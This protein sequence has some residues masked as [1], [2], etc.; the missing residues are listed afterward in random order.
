[1]RWSPVN[2]LKF[3]IWSAHEFGC[4]QRCWKPI[5]GWILEKSQVR[6]SSISWVVITPGKIFLHLMTTTWLIHAVGHRH[7][8]NSGSNSRQSLR[9]A[10]LESVGNRHNLYNFDELMA[11]S[12]RKNV[13]IRQWFKCRCTLAWVA[14]LH[15]HYCKRVLANN[16]RMQCLSSVWLNGSKQRKQLQYITVI[17]C[18]NCVG[19]DGSLTHCAPTY[20]CWWYSVTWAVF[21]IRGRIYLANT[22]AITEKQ[23]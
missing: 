12:E 3:Q 8:K 7:I 18:K 17:Q 2:K 15:S 22:I 21:V 19:F 5:E 9:S 14:L 6:Q 20:E 16:L 10:V 1:M 4:A 11:K 23:I 13:C